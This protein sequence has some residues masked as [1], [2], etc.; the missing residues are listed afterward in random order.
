[1]W[2]VFPRFRGSH[3]KF[4]PRTSRLHPQ[5]DGMVE[6]HVQAV[7]EHLR[8]VFLVHQRDWDERL[9]IFLL[10][11]KASMHEATSTTPASIVFWNEA[12]LPCDLLFGALTD[13]EQSTTD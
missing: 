7:E 2:K 9:P 12:R 6:R 1:M 3:L 10:A 4:N 8:K 13:K 5:F 11:C